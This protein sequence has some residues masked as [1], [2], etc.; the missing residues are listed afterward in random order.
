MFIFIFT[1][2]V[3]LTNC[4]QIDIKIESW[5]SQNFGKPV[6]QN[7]VLSLTNEGTRFN[8]RI[9]DSDDARH[10]LIQLCLCC[11]LAFIYQKIL[12]IL[13]GKLPVLKHTFYISYIEKKT[14]R[15]ASK[16]NTTILK[17]FFLWLW[18]RRS[19]S[20]LNECTVTFHSRSA[21]NRRKWNNSTKTF[22]LTEHRKYAVMASFCPD[23][24]IRR[25]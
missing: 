2:K 16:C 4:N 9:W 13:T 8:E 5:I 18:N 24:S 21:S 20:E 14:R 19:Q 11:N 10:K 1:P 3:L 23:N 15:K 22:H 6:G 12:F 17:T 25:Q 7:K